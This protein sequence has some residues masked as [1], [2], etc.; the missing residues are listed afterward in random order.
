MIDFEKEL[1]KLLSSECGPLETDEFAIIA[2]EGNRVLAALNKKQADISLQVE[3]I[4]DI[5]REDGTSRDA[6][7]TERSKVASLLDAVVGLTDLLDNFLRY[8]EGNGR[9]ELENQ[10]RIMVKNAGALHEKCAIASFGEAGE[11][12]RPELH[13]VY[14]V[15]A[16]DYPR[17]HIVNVLECGYRYMGAVIRKATVTVSAGAG[18]MSQISKTQTLTGGFF[19]LFSGKTGRKR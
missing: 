4:Y 7:L 19:K 10:A 15:E 9:P 18:D 17:E 5:V 11:P 14:S 3:E 8:A 13:T 16:S 12:L 1:D 2:D 6:L